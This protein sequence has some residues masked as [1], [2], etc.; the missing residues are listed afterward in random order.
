VA[1]HVQ[2]AKFVPLVGGAAYVHTLLPPL[3][4][5]A[6]VDETVV[7]EKV[8]VRVSVCAVCGVWCAVVWDSIL[9]TCGQLIVAGGGHAAN[10]CA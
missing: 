4:S 6:I 2:L 7:R 9:R 10:P 3:E 5:L 8:R 1:H